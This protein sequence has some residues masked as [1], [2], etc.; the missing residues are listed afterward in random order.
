MAYLSPQM[1]AIIRQ[2]TEK[3]MTDRCLIEREQNS[4]DAIGGRTHTWE[5]VGS[6]IP[7]RMITSKAATLPGTDIVA[8]RESMEDTYTISLPYT[9]TLAA[10]YRITVNGA[11]FNVSRVLDGRTD[12]ADVQAVLIR[13]RGDES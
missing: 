12:G 1:R 3:Q 10:D 7:C 2:Q 9:T 4:R 11:A 5:T 6:N 13:M 8:D